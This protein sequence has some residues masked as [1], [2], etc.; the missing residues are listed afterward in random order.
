MPQSLQSGSKALQIPEAGRNGKIVQPS[1]EDLTHPTPEFVYALMP[2]AAR[3]IGELGEQP[4]LVA[5]R[6]ETV[7]DRRARR[8]HPALENRISRKPHDVSDIVAVAPVEHPVPAEPRV[9]SQHDPH[10]LYERIP[11][12]PTQRLRP[13]LDEFDVMLAEYW[14]YKRMFAI[15]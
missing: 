6:A 4:Y 5:C 15:L 8:L 10:M 13:L 14:L 3:C 1:V 9:P 2:P 7:L 11:N 12:W